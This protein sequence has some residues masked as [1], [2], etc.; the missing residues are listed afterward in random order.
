MKS[1]RVLRLTSGE[2]IICELLDKQPDEECIR[3]KFPFVVT[4]DIESRRLMY[5]PFAPFSTATGLVDVRKTSLTF[6]SVPSSHLVDQYVDLLEGN[7][8]QSADE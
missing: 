7:L 8:N 6:M 3:V 2:H 4:H 5:S 1:A